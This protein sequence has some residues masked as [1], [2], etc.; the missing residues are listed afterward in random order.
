MNDRFLSLQLFARVARTGSF[1][2]AGREMGVS[3]PTASRIVAALE[4]KVGVAL[5]TRTT[6]GVALTEAGSDYLV[7]AEAILAALDEADHAARGTGE[8]RGVLRV[9]MSTSTALRCVLPRLSRFTDLHPNLRI[10]FVLNDERQD[11]IGDGIDVALRVGSLPDSA[12]TA[13]KVGVVFR[14]LAASPVY[15]A[16]AGTPRVPSDLTNHSIIVGPASR[17][18]EGW[19]FKKD[20]KA[21]SVRVEGRFVLNG[22]EGATAAAV[23][24]LGIVSNGAFG[25]MKEL[26]SGALVRV[27]PDWEMGTAEAHV[28]LAAGR[29]A[30]PSARAFSDFT[31]SQFRELEATWDRIERLAPIPDIGFAVDARAPAAVAS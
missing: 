24:G 12:A 22:A 18:M 19:A 13:R 31:Y 27:L 2:I 25:M 23:A 9:A 14:T 5:L 17:G 8:L 7:R 11:L 1:S 30:K 20:G 28:I 21:T 15:L 16:K 4:K 3:Q 26:E 10:E 29:A 6:R